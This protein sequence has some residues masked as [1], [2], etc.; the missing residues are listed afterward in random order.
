MCI[1]SKKIDI[2]V[3]NG[4]PKSPKATELLLASHNLMNSL[5]PPEENH[6]LS[7]DEL[8]K[9]NALF[10][11]ARDEKE[12]LGCVAMINYGSYGEIK[13][14]FVSSEVRNSGI[15]K[16]LLNEVIKRAHNS[17]IGCLRLETGDLLRE[18]ISLYRSLGFEQIDP[19]GDYEANQSSLFMELKI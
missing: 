13:S 3:E 14:L 17:K 2:T 10:L 15:A 11:I 12:I 4:D 8:C 9:S 18:A 1:A 7:V 16:K 19:F 6:Y 5:F